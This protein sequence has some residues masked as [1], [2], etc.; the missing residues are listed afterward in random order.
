[1]TVLILL[2]AMIAVFSFTLG[3]HLGKKIAPILTGDEHKTPNIDGANDA[4]PSREEIA[5]QTKGRT[6][7]VPEV[8]GTLEDSLK[9]EVQENGLKLDNPRET[10]IPETTRAEEV[11]NKKQNKDLNKHGEL[12]EKSPEELVEEKSLVVKD[13]K[14][15]VTGHAVA[16]PDLHNAADTSKATENAEAKVEHAPSH[17]AKHAPEHVAEHDPKTVPTKDHSE[18]STHS[19]SDVSKTVNVS[20]HKIESGNVSGFVL[21]LGSFP[22]AADANKKLTSL[23]GHVDTSQELWIQEANLPKK[24][25]WYRLYFGFFD[26]KTKAIEKAE[27]LVSTHLIDSYIVTKAEKK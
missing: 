21:Q 17:S 23:Q 16:P 22:T 19:E 27:K 24:G 12:D 11:K 20:E 25:V 2:G 18:A 13:A 8:A 26:E 1:M 4:V 6:P 10:K 3:I 5:D 7:L 15:D 14:L 9:K